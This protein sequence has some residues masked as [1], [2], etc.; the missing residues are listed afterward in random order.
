VGDPLWEMQCFLYVSLSLMGKKRATVKG[1][2]L[3]FSIGRVDIAFKI[4]Q[5]SCLTIKAN[6]SNYKFFPLSQYLQGM[7]WLLR[8]CHPYGCSV[9]SEM[10]IFV[11]LKTVTKWKFQI[12]L[13]LRHLASW[14]PR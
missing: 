12:F 2:Q 4:L 3:F 1:T 7:S 6:N 13:A 14:A 9:A 8:D 11:K 10:E 5:P